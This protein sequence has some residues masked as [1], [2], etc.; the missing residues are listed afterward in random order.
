VVNIRPVL[1]C[2]LSGEPATVL[3]GSR[4]LQPA[5]AI[6][7]TGYGTTTFSPLAAG[8]LSGK[9]LEGT[10]E[11]S[12][13]KLPG[14]EWLARLL[15]DDKHNGRI[16]ALKGVAAELGATLAQLAIAWCATNPNVSTVITGASR[17]EQVVEN[18]GAL[19][20]IERLDADVLARMDAIVGRP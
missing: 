18:M 11:G 19:A 8:L 6:A 14:Y 7:D 13:A 4:P 5:C 12:R 9:Y 3:R 1:V 17:P 2:R 15:L 20:V 16:V 10:P